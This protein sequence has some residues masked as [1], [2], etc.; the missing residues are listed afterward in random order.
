MP[1]RTS[2]NTRRKYISYDRYGKKDVEKQHT[3][4]NF[5]KNFF[6]CKEELWYKYEECLFETDTPCYLVG[7]WQSWKYFQSIRQKLCEDFCF[8]E[9]FIHL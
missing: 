3:Y 2:R 9:L 6:F 1:Q 5:L 8:S 4:H 7:Y